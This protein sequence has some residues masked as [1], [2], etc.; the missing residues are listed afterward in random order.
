MSIF[1]ELLE[2]V[3]SAGFGFTGGRLCTWDSSVCIWS[4]VFRQQIHV[5]AE[6]KEV[7]IA[8]DVAEMV[9]FVTTVK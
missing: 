2:S 4:R 7:E 9:L 5:L 8:L 3:Q 6:R 1:M